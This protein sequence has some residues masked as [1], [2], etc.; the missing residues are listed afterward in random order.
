MSLSCTQTH[1]KDGDLAVV[2]GYIDQLLLGRFEAV[3]DQ[4]LLAFQENFQQHLP[5]VVQLLW[6]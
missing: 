3:L 5:T 2:P 1:V 6:S 4:V